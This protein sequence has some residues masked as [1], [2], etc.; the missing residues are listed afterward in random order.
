MLVSKVS[1]AFVNTCTLLSH[2]E[3]PCSLFKAVS[4]NGKLAKRPETLLVHVSHSDALFS[5]V[6]V[7]ST[8]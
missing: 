4:V 7:S 2:P 6:A 8:L 1:K 3:R 5:A